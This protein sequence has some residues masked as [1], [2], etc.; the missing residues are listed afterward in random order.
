MLPTSFCSVS[1]RIGLYMRTSAITARLGQL[2]EGGKRGTNKL[3][4]RCRINHRNAAGGGLLSVPHNSLSCFESICRSFQ[5]PLRPKP[6]RSSLPSRPHR[7]R[8]LCCRSR[9]SGSS[10]TPLPSGPMPRTRPLAL[11]RRPSPA[12]AAGRGS[13]PPPSLW[14]GGRCGRY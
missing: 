2:S 8:A 7:R 13:A 1:S 5:W 4:T 12:P 10:P 9:A 3:R 6:R 11:A 14:A